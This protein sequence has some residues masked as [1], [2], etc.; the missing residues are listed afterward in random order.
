MVL[1]ILVAS[2]VIALILGVHIAFEGPSRLS[3]SG[4]SRDIRYIG[5]AIRRAV[6]NSIGLV[7]VMKEITSQCERTRTHF[8]RHLVKCQTC[9]A[10]AQTISAPRAKNFAKRS[11]K[12]SA[13]NTTANRVPPY[14]NSSTCWQARRMRKDHTRVHSLIWRHVDLVAF[15]SP[16]FKGASETAWEEFR[17]RRLCLRP[18]APRASERR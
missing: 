6:S 10:L 3:M 5:G 18:G 1:G 2:V 17:E 14:H 16:R 15:C 12:P 4:A 13:S 8:V 11:L 7:N 9:G